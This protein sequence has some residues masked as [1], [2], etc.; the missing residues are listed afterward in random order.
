MLIKTNSIKMNKVV[1]ILAI[2]FM[3]AW[4]LVVFGTTCMA[5]FRVL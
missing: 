3:V 4:L 2:F 5:F 1:S